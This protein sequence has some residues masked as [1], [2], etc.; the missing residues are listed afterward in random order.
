MSLGLYRWAA[1]PS[2][3]HVSP[4]LTIHLCYQPSP[5]EWGH[6]IFFQSLIDAPYFHPRSSYYN[7]GII[8]QHRCISGNF[9]CPFPAGAVSIH[10]SRQRSKTKKRK[11]KQTLKQA[12]LPH[13]RIRPYI[14]PSSPL[15]EQPI[16][17]IACRN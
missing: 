4:L 17:L 7:K 8:Q 12:N 16:Y 10:S 15:P 5:N 3:L 11:R 14:T 2:S 6:L 9:W 1:I 13:P